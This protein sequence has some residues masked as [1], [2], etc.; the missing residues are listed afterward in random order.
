MQSAWQSCE[1]STIISVSNVVKSFFSGMVP[2]IGAFSTAH[3]LLYSAKMPYVSCV[4]YV[5]GVVDSYCLFES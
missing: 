4:L 3:N 1:Y 2:V 5:C